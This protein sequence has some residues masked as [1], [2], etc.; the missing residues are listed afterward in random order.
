MRRVLN[1]SDS[2]YAGKLLFKLTCFGSLS[3]TFL[4]SWA[5]VVRD[6][7]DG[8]PGWKLFFPCRSGRHVSKTR[9]SN[10]PRG[11]RCHIF[12]CFVGCLWCIAR[13]PPACMLNACMQAGVMRAAWSHACMHVRAYMHVCMYMYVCTYVHECMYVRTYVCMYVCMYVGM[14]VC[15]HAASCVHARRHAA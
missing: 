4:L 6:L 5:L 2:N 14:Y 9:P 7:P 1:S 15:M 11:G 8:N 10:R 3:P 12:W 13:Y